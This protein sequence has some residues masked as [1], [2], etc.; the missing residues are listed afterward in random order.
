MRWIALLFVVS[1]AGAQDYKPRG[2][3]HDKY[4]FPITLDAEVI[5]LNDLV[6]DSNVDSIQELGNIGSARDQM[7][8]DKL[9][10]KVGEL[11]GLEVEERAVSDVIER[12]IAAYPSEA[13]FYDSLAQK[14]QTLELYRQDI[15]RQ[16]L[17]YRLDSLIK[18]G[19]LQ[20]GQRL[21]PW[22]PN[23]SPREVKIAFD[24]DPA[25]VAAGSLVKWREIAVSLTAKERKKVHGKRMLNPDLTDEDL[26]KE[27]NAILEPRV[28]QARAALKAKK[29]LDEIAKE[30]GAT[31]LEKGGEIDSEPTKSERLTFLQKAKKGEQSGLLS[32]GE[33]RFAILQIVDVRRPDQM[34]LNNPKVVEGYRARV[35]QLK[36]SK[37][38]FTLRLRALEKSIIRPERVRQQLR[39]LL[40]TS[41][42]QSH[43]ELRVLGLH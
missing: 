10:E 32:V 6:R 16:V 33:A 36:Q 21:L 7:L 5:T 8:M 43:P 27:E 22:D 24:N 15:K 34:T 26:Q 18:G 28:A 30:L 39:D 29:S 1:L 23:P 17:A 41:L 40:L 42:R 37:A 9:T 12:Q 35:A 3:D 11:Y 19:F 2:D 13:E 14:G 4:G 25:R 31:V 20:Q 38:N